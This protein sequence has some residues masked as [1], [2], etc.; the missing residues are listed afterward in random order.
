M[1][2]NHIIQTSNELEKLWMYKKYGANLIM[3]SSNNTEHKGHV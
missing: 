2:E 1:N 3:N